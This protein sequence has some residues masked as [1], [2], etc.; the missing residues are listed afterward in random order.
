[1]VAPHGTGDGRGG[2]EGPRVFLHIDM[3]NGGW[4]RTAGGGPPEN[5]VSHVRGSLAT[6]EARWPWVTTMWARHDNAVA[7][8]DICLKLPLDPDSCGRLRSL[9]PERG[10]DPRRSRV[11][12]GYG[13][14]ARRSRPES[15]VDASHTDAGAFHRFRPRDPAGT[16][17]MEWQERSKG[18][19]RGRR[20]RRTDHA[21]RRSGG[22]PARPYRRSPDAR[23]ADTGVRSRPGP[24]STAGATRLPVGRG[25]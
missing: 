10:E 8:S 18:M 22:A 14:R 25:D 3:E 23:P 12:H 24:S 13:A 5:R 15:V 1:M 9:A 4:M 20:H 2:D 7:R 21:G 17:G 6:G 16:N 19:G 11:L